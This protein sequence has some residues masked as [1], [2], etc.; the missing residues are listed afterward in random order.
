MYWRDIAEQ[1]AREARLLEAKLRD[2]QN[3]LLC[4]G[5]L[6][7]TGWGAVVGIIARGAGGE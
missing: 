7:L 4:Y 1:K 3:T 6:A 5:L 2:A